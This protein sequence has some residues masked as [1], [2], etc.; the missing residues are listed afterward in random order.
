MRTFKIIPNYISN[1]NIAVLIFTITILS[2]SACKEKIDIKLKETYVRLVIEG[3][4]TNETK[5][6]TIKITQTS[7]YFSNEAQPLVSGAIVTLNDGVNSAI[8]TE[9]SP[10]IYQTDSNYTGVI[11]KLYTL[12]VKYENEEFTASSLLKNVAE[13]DSVTFGY[14]PF[15]PAKRTVN[16]WAQ[17][18]ATYGDYY[19]WL[20]YVNG[21]LTSDTLKEWAFSDDLMVNGN[22]ISG[23]PVYTIDAEPGD[24]I[25]LEMKSITKDYYDFIYAV[26]FE[27]YGAGSPFS[28]PP[29][30]VKGNVIN[31]THK[32][33]EVMGYFIASAVSRKSDI[34]N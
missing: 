23:F 20:Y 11:G 18:P 22:Y 14:D 27:V 31:L 19:L 6:H 29:A 5:R 4:I 32:E 26:F 30:N 10:G 9:T 16:L 13:V 28:G 2:F 7:N 8:L 3:E 12:N 21:V 25:T 24:T 17:E 15:F 1:K 34:L 33:K